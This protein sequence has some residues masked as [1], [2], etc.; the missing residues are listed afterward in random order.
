MV[1]TV[2]VGT[3][4]SA[5]AVNPV[6]NKIFVANCIPPSGGIGGSGTPGTVTVIDGATDSTTTIPAGIC[7]TAVAVNSVTN[8]IYVANFGRSSITCGSCSTGSITV[9]DGATNTGVTITDPNAKSPHAVAVNSATNKIYVVN[10]SSDNVTVLDG[11]TN[12]TTTI[13]DP[14]AAFPFAV[15]VN[16]T[17][18]KIYVG[19]QG[20]FLH[21]GTNPGNVTV[22]DGATNSITTVADPNAINPVGLAVNSVT[23]K[24]YVVNAGNYPASNH[25]NVSVIDG[26]TNAITTVPID[27]NA[28]T[29]QALAVNQTTNKIYVANAND[30]ALTANGGVTIIDGATNAISTVKDP[31]AIIPTAVAVDSMTN[32]IYVVNEGCFPPADSCGAQGSV[33]VINGAKDAVTTVIDPQASHPDSVAVNPTTNKIYVANL[34]GNTTVIDGSAAPTSH[35]LVVELA[36]SGSGIVMSNPSGINCGNSCS[37]GFAPGTMVSLTASPA[38]GSRFSGWSGS[39]SGVGACTVTMNADEAVTSTFDAGPPAD[40]SLAPASISLT[41]L[42][43]GQKTDV[44]T[45]APQNGSF[46]SAIQLACTVSGST[47]TATCALSPNSVTPG[48]NSATSTLTVT[49]PAQTAGLIPF[50]EGQVS[51]K[52][53][54]SFLPMPLALIG[55][56]LSSSKAN[57]QRRQ[58]WL[59]C[60]LFLVSVALQT[61]CGGG[62]GNQLTPPPPLNYTVT[63]TAT[64]GAIQHTT[65]VSVTV[66]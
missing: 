20:S 25:G 7:P 60:S 43:G 24:V 1:A 17:T 58:L 33:T 22:I 8:K 62:S 15:A 34:G 14:N 52:L 30:S 3:H 49:A 65:Q 39:C 32:M 29:P 27:P 5:I 12:T 18:N 21:N 19:N 55:L 63:V 38:S 66:P 11:A 35:I 47:P 37:A 57:H 42:A 64:S 2:P 16:S 23:N 51:S 56:A 6:T 44:I 9:I 59:L 28:L 48:A 54:A 26:T 40:F 50:G 4:P 31:N 45:I 13:T 53:Y 46:G 41:V 36:G 10:N 61:G